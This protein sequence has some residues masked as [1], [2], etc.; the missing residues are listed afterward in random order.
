MKKHIYIHKKCA[1][2]FGCDNSIY[3]GGR[4]FCPPHYSAYLNRVKRGKMTWE[5][6]KERT[7]HFLELTE[8]GREYLRIRV[9]EN[10]PYARKK[11]IKI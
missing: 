3:D 5:E 1:Y 7:F 4:G 11:Y 8:L 10:Y 2:A 9:Q 6:I